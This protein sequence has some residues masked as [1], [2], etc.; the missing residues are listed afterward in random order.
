MKKLLAIILALCMM[1]SLCA[2][3]EKESEEKKEEYLGLY[4]GVSVVLFGENVDMSEVYDGVNSIELKSGGKCEITLQ[5][6]TQNATYKV[7]GKEMTLNIEGENITATLQEGIIV[8]DFF[9]TEMTF[10]KKGYQVS[11]GN[12]NRDDTDDETDIDNEGNSSDAVFPQLFAEDMQGDWHGWCIVEDA[13]G[14]YEDDIGDEFEII[15]RFAFDEEG[16]CEPFL[17]LSVEEDMNFSDL[18]VSYNEFG[19]LMQMEGTVFGTDI[20]PDTN[21]YVLD[22]AIWMN[23]LVGE[24]DDYMDV[25]I[26][27]RHLDDEWDE[28]YDYPCMPA[29][30]IEYYS[31]MSME[32]LMELYGLDPA[33]L[34][35]L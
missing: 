28:E 11:T 26:C 35:E 20:L 15:A 34:P 7:N 6:D 9:G 30:A 21:L 29:E 10:A 22:G 23:L 2:C 8:M 31:G 25:Y 18:E 3:N 16:H 4:E 17:A 13:G 5:G 1:L 14:I 33:V 19:D 12:I 27:M 32:D 24:S